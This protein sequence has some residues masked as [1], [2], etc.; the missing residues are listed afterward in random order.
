MASTPRW[1]EQRLGAHA[2][3]ADG[4]GVHLDGH[5]RSAV[6]EC[7]ARRSGGLFDRQVGFA[8]GREAA[9]E[10][11]GLLVARA[12]SARASARV[13]RARR[14]GTPA[15]AAA[16]CSSAARVEPL[17]S[18]PSGTLRAPTAWP[19]AYSSGFADVDQHRL[20]AV[21]QLH[22]LAGADSVPPPAPR[23]SMRPEQHAAGDERHQDAAS[24]CRRGTSRVFACAQHGGKA[25]DYRM[26]ALHRSLTA[27][28]PCTSSS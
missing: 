11:L 24:S 7:R 6:R 22:R 26:S 23:A 19:A 1:L 9:G 14:W 16:P 2:V 13:A 8:P 18:W 5:V 15:P 12:S 25:A 27:L 3:R 20:L 10:R 21:D 28:P 17:S 4:G